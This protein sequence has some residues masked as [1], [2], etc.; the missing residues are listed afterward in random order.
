VADGVRSEIAAVEQLLHLQDLVEVGLDGGI[1]GGAGMHCHLKAVELLRAAIGR[2]CIVG[3]ANVLG[4][5]HA[6]N[7]GFPGVAKGGFERAGIEFVGGRSRAGWDF[8]PELGPGEGGDTD[9]ALDSG[10]ALGD[11]IARAATDG[12][13]TRGRGVVLGGG[14]FD[15]LLAIANGAP[16]STGRR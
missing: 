14:G 11:E 7:Q 6:A 4:S 2:G 9:T 13:A 8:G 16:N 12:R 10:A 5:T 3:L 1:E 15:I